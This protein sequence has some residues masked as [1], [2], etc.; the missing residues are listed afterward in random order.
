MFSRAPAKVCFPEIQF[1]H[2]PGLGLP[3]KGT[4]LLERSREESSGEKAEAHQDLL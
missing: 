2:E 1:P 4:E 3:V